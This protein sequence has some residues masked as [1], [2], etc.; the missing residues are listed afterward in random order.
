VVRLEDNTLMELHRSCF[1]P[2]QGSALSLATHTPASAVTQTTYSHAQL[3]VPKL[4]V[5]GGGM[6]SGSKP[7]PID[8]A[9]L[10]EHK[11]PP[12]P[13][14][15]AMSDRSSP[16]QVSVCVCVCVCLCMHSFRGCYRHV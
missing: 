5:S 12:F 1:N 9:L 6:L 11:T 16:L 15:T 2:E 7:T 4:P 8:M 13:S 14:P 10:G 3:R